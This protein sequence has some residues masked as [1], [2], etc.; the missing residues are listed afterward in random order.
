LWQLGDSLVESGHRDEAEKIFLD[1][2]QTIDRAVTDFP[3]NVNFR[4]QLAISEL[5]LGIFL[6]AGKRIEEAAPH[7]RNALQK[8][9]A[10]KIEFP[11]DPQHAVLEIDTGIAF[12][13]ASLLSARK[14]LAAEGF[15]QAVALLRARAGLGDAWS[16]DRL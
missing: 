14:D 12:G 9:A 4:R 5:K 13:D 11:D 10:L 2:L 15:Q 7:F 8:A 1:A 6:G 16:Q 3:K